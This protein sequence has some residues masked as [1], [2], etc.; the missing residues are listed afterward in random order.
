MTSPTRAR[1]NSSTPMLQRQRSMD[2][3]KSDLGIMVDDD[4]S[5]DGIEMHGTASVL[6]QAHAASLV[7]SV[8][9]Y[10][11]A[12][13]RRLKR[14]RIKL[15]LATVRLN[16]LSGAGSDTTQARDALDKAIRAL[17]EL[18]LTA[19]P[20]QL[21][22]QVMSA[23]TRQAYEAHFQ[24]LGEFETA[25]KAGHAKH[26]WNLAAG[27]A[28]NF[29]SFGIGGLIG[30]WAGNPLLSLPINTLLWTF[31]EP[32]VSMMRATTFTNPNLDLYM[33]RQ[34]LQGR[35]A[36]EAL[37]RTSGLERNRKFAWVDPVSQETELLNAAD[38]LAR[39]SWLNLWSGKYLTDDVPTYLYTVAYSVANSLPE[40]TSADLYEN[41]DYGKWMRAGIRTSAGVAAGAALQECVQLLRAS[42][43][44]RTGGKELVTR[45]T[46]LW[47]REAHVI[48]LVLQDIEARQNDAG[49]TIEKEQA[50]A[51]LHRSFTLWHRKAVAKSSMLGSICYEWDA[52][53]Q[54]KR[55]AIGIDPEVPGKRLY[56]G[57]SFIGKGLAQLPGLA[58][59][60][61][62]AGVVKSPVAWI[63]WVGYLTP[64]L[65]MIGAAGFIVRRELEV[66]AH[67]MLSAAH[68]IGR[69]CCPHEAED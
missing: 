16:Q 50:Y 69:S 18:L 36:R 29:I 20:A 30:A 27:G 42:Q 48:G 2:A 22:N 8:S 66:L 19:D 55:E 49:L 15:D 43:A 37:D 24:A 54:P 39:T 52:M 41:I 63:R 40:F 65:A 56:T 23:A 34:R 9:R 3:D 33:V 14:S 51:T 13:Q 58:T 67:T 31:A 6:A 12:L 47:K 64:P 26:L 1:T 57:A 59:S 62:A 46:A 17:G 68:G 60:Q 7:G 35:A 11:L 21:L 32:L 10:D 5:N 28:G 25:V 45:T 44:R 53:L 38:W 4:R 61:L